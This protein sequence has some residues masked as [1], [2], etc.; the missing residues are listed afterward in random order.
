[1][2][3]NLNDKIKNTINYLS[4]QMP[5]SQGNR[6]PVENLTVEEIAYIQTYL[7]H[8]KA[9]KIKQNNQEKRNNMNR[10]TDVY[11]PIDREVPVDWRDYRL[12]NQQV[13]SRHEWNPRTKQLDTPGPQLSHNIPEPGS[14]GSIST[15]IGKKMSNQDGYTGTNNYNLMNTRPMNAGPT[16]AGPMNAGP[17]NAN[18]AMATGN[19]Y[20]NPYE[21]GARQN[22]LGFVKRDV[23]CGPYQN[24]PSM[25]N[26]IG[27]TQNQSDEKFPG[28][29]RNVN[30]ESYLMQK[31]ATHL[32]GQR[33]I[34]Q[35]EFDRF[36][37][38]PFDPQDPKHI[39]W[40]DMPRGG[41]PTRVDRLEL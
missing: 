15:R 1:M 3:Q 26:Q 23:V 2:D 41:F 33:E 12:P 8:I 21:Y 6:N 32:P 37:L 29:I 4:Q 34:T 7:E 35:K 9:N 13:P 31:E 10:A 40:N 28:Q 20:H 17:T 27:L 18:L 25:L 14:R 38:L 39:V 30:V 11:D 24:D 36:Q 22:H 5:S 16:N 19:D